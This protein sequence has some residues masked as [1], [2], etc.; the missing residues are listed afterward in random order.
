M[1]RAVFGLLPKQMRCCPIGQFA[2]WS[3]IAS[4]SVADATTRI[5]AAL[6]RLPAAKKKLVLSAFLPHDPDGQVVTDRKGQPEPEPDLRDQES[7]PL[8]RF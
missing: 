2:G 1:H 6:P 3:G 7:V 5:A 4:A 8:T